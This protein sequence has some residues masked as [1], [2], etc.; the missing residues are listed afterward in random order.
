MKFINTTIYC[1]LGNPS[2]LKL[3]HV[4]FEKFTPSVSITTEK[5]ETAE[6]LIIRYH[7]R[8]ANVELQKYLTKIKAK[9]DIYGLFR[10][11]T[12]MANAKIQQERKYP[13]LLLAS[14][15]LNAII[16]THYH[17][18]TF[19]SGVSRCIAKIREKF[20]IPKIRRLL[21]TTITHCVTCKRYQERAYAYPP[22]HDLP[23]ERVLR[24][25]SVI[26]F[27]GAFRKLIARRGTPELVISDNASSFKL[28]SEILVNELPQYHKDSSVRSFTTYNGLRWKFITPFAPRK[29]GFY[30]R[31]VGSV[32]MSLKKIIHKAILIP[33]SLET[34][35]VE[36]EGMLNTRP[37]TPIHDSSAD[38]KSF[39]TNRLD[40]TIG[41]SP[42][43]TKSKNEG[44]VNYTYHNTETEEFAKA[45]FHS[46]NVNLDFWAIWQRDYLAA[47]AQRHQV[48]E[49]KFGHK[50]FPE[51]GDLVLLKKS[52][53]KDR[54]G[55]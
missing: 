54:S 34:L 42:F 21:R 13:I 53:L 17:V 44:K 5:F 49:N 48:K 28:G 41:T 18:K 55:H 37:I 10:E 2:K 30:E 52:Q 46:L 36:I 38:A 22:S 3:E 4:G 29:G 33:R 14:R 32:K 6:R 31:L 27:L 20:F 23:K 47:L 35:L 1:K 7:Y 16:A 39:A 19:H 9:E 43:V 25:N 24:N 11:A 15:H 45:W 51:E 26:E 50:T 40:S 12:R 8:E